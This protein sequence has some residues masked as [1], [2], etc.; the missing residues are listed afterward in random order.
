MPNIL[1][2][3]KTI[4]MKQLLQKTHSQTKLFLRSCLLN[5]DLEH[6]PLQLLKFPNFTYKQTRSPKPNRLEQSTH[7]FQYS[8]PLNSLQ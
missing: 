2:G 4:T 8:P 6:T 5:S 1:Q 7:P 3:S